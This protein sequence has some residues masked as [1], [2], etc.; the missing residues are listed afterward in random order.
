MVAKG[1]C[2]RGEFETKQTATYWPP[3]PLTL[4]ALLSRSAGQLNQG[5]W[6]PMALCWMLVLSTASYLQLTDSNY[7]NFLLHRVISLFDAHLLPV[8]VTPA[9][10]STCPQSR[11]Y[12]DIFDRMHLFLDWWL[13]RR[14]ICYTVA[15]TAYLPFLCYWYC[16]SAGQ[17]FIKCGTSLFTG[18]AKMRLKM[19]H[20]L[21]GSMCHNGYYLQPKFKTWTRL[22]IFHFVLML[23]RK[24]WPHFFSSQLG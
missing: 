5:S 18:V 8:S 21:F 16:P 11:L 7:L 10:N 20:C 9:S 17:R 23:L 15:Y 1:L 12:P 2:V 22:F 13:G 24:A 4:A 6:G 3:V 14:S 19:Y